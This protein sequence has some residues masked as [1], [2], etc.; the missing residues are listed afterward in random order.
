MGL[1]ARLCE[2]PP[3][4]FGLALR[5]G[6]Y[7]QPRHPLKQCY[8]CHCSTSASAATSLSTSSTE[9]PLCSLVV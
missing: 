6:P 1:S 2:G 3:P 9:V 4:L 7:S 8:A 5:P